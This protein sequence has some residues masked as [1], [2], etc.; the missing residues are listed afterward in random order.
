MKGAIKGGGRGDIPVMPFAWP[1]GK[2]D[3]LNAKVV[4]NHVQEVVVRVC[5]LALVL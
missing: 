3:D 1:T 4:G 2:K 5:G